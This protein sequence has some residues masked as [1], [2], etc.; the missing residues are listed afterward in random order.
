M[1]NDIH[2][3]IVDTHPDKIASRKLP[4]PFPNLQQAV[5]ALGF[6]RRH[7]QYPECL[8]ISQDVNTPN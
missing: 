5:K 7:H 6:L 1:N 4:T 2:Y 3:F 8:S